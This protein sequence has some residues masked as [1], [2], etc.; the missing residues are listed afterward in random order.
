MQLCITFHS[1]CETS[2]IST[3]WRREQMRLRLR[4]SIVTRSRI[5]EHRSFLKYF[6]QLIFSLG[7]FVSHLRT[8]GLVLKVGA[9][10]EGRIKA[11]ISDPYVSMLYPVQ[12]GGVL[13][14][15]QQQISYHHQKFQT[16]SPT[17]P[18]QSVRSKQ[19]NM[20]KKKKNLTYFLIPGDSCCLWSDWCESV[21]GW[22]CS[23]SSLSAGAP[24][25]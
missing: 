1:T 23:W 9:L 10:V 21:S 24:D 12:D 25:R 7:S 19:T 13:V 8:F 15:S 18:D 3:L 11:P 22:R 20:K 2:S 6:T 16:T 5:G 4:F 17:H 14:L